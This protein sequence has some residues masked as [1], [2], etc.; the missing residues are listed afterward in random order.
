MLR[1][2][3]FL[4]FLLTAASARAQPRDAAAILRSL[5]DPASR[6]VLVVA[7]RGDWRTAPEN[8]LLSLEAAIALGVDVVEI[9]LKRS[10]D[11][12]LFLL[13]DLTLDRTTTG[14]G[15][16]ADYPWAELQRLTLKNEH[17]G[18][19]R[20]RLPSFE[21]F[22]RAAKGR[23]LVNLDQGYPYLQQLYEVLAQTGTVQQ[24]LFKSAETYEKLRA[25][26]PVFPL[27]KVL[28]M[29]VVNLAQPGA[30][31][32]IRGYEAHVKAVAYELNFPADSCLLRSAY[33]SI[34]AS[35][36]KLW[37]NSLWGSL[38][39]NHDDERSVEEHQP[40]DG[41]GWLLAHGAALIQTDRP[42]A[43]LAYLRQQGRH[44]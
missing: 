12:V 25:E 9:D 6:E 24:A 23:V 40:A 38:D 31:A 11:G 42:A 33:R 19:T 32:A 8:S 37:Y 39:A 1:F 22:M 43:L 7:H 20:Q 34:P 21:Q 13:H 14:H 3:S 41:W 2:L 18:P 5:R 16:P 10:K 4:T 15:A 35:G 44:P 26:N 17:G 27:D 30:A 36:A 29:P 28:Y